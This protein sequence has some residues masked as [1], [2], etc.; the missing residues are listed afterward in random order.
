MFEY[1]YKIEK[2]KIT[3]IFVMTITVEPG[4]RKHGIWKLGSIGNII[5]V[6]KLLI[7][8]NMLTLLTTFG[9]FSLLWKLET[10][11]QSIF[12]FPDIRF[13]SGKND[14]RSSDKE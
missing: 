9:F 13:L 5:V 2:I 10:A 14:H 3:K 1:L 7:S 11:Y 12:V 8:S 4:V 6:K